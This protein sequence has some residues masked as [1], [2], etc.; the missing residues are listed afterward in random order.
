MDQLVEFLT[1]NTAPPW[2]EPLYWRYIQ[3]LPVM[4]AGLLTTLLLTPIAGFIA[5]KFNIVN[6]TKDH[7]RSVLNRF[8]NIER[9]INPNAVPLLGGLAV[10]VP[11]M[12]FIIL[13]FGFNDI[14][15]PIILG[16]SI[17]IV[18][19]V[20]DDIYNLPATAQFGAQILAASIVAFSVIDLEYISI[21]F[22]GILYLDQWTYTFEFGSLPGSIVLLGD[23]IMIIW[24]LVMIN[25]IKW[26]GGVDALMESTVGVAFIL[27]YVIAL[28]DQNNLIA[29][30][31]IFLFGSLI[32]FIFYN[33][34]PAKIFSGSVGKSSY[35][36]I[37]ATF[38]ILN[39][40]KVAVTIMIL[41][42]PLMDFI[43]VLVKRTLSNR[44][45][46]VGELV[47]HPL[48]IMRMSDTN[49]LHHQLLKLGFTN[50]Q[51][52]LI[53]IGV[54]LLLGIVAV[55]IAEAYRLVFLFGIG[56]IV[57]MGILLLHILAKRRESKEPDKK[58]EGEKESPESR[59]SY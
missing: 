36:F 45:R 40:A 14:T 20:L 30:S 21:P 15:I 19:G 26:V 27:L 46:T 17:L 41:L 8:E 33:F 35:G 13:F 25:A 44:P 11:F 29:I 37:L 39:D 16:L 4:I 10:L 3:F 32:G 50:R 53:E 7:K 59:Y 9:R 6:E 2:I 51:V 28:R 1:I 54:S 48:K 42:L 23:L 22:D 5:Q 43:F 56:I 18:S 12:L 38:A 58:D 34:P 49:H 47:T 57:I 31:S 55:T 24:M 52:L